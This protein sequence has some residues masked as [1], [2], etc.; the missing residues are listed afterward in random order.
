VTEALIIRVNGEQAAPINW[1]IWSQAEQEIIA[2]GILDGADELDA[3]TDKAHGRECVL[4]LPASHAQ[5]KRVTLPSKWGSKLQQALPFIIEDEIASDID[6]VF[7]AIGQA[8]TIDDK[9]L[10]DVAIVDD[11]WM[12]QWLECLA[13]HG[14]TPSRVLPDAMLLP[15]PSDTQHVSAIELDGTWLFRGTPWHI[16]QVELPWLE[17]YLHAQKVETVCHYSPCNFTGVNLESNPDEV[18]LPL[19]IF[20]RQLPHCPFNLLQG[21]YKVKKQGSPFWRTWRAPLIAASVALVLSLGF[22]ATALYQINQQLIQSEA[23]ITAQYL[24]AFP[25]SK[26]RF[27]LIRNQIRNR[28]AAVDGGAES[29]FL[30]LME[31]IVPV[32]SSV[33]EFHPQSLRYD[34]KRQELRFR[35]VGQDFQSFNQVKTELEKRGLSIEQGGLN[36]EG[37][38]VVG[39]LKVRVQ[40]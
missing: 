2:S 18:D 11:E 28:L 37:D 15:V 23:D 9:H 20:A 10:L 12:A 38:T 3:L 14:L 17:M 21:K 39:E 19:A 32:F 29:D 13:S 7:I 1:L 8:H 34:A 16:A 6:D 24:S 30:A 25:G 22:K 27:H 4:L 31:M 35:A 33:K 40:S 5:L 36:N 26:V